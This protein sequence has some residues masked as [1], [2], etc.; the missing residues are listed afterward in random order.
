MAAFEP[1]SWEQAIDEITSK[2][3]GLVDEHGPRSLAYM[4]ASA[5]GGERGLGDPRDDV[6][7]QHLARQRAGLVERVGKAREA[8]TLPLLD[9]IRLRSLDSSGLWSF[10][11]GQDFHVRLRFTSV[12]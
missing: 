4:G 8:P 12:S 5:Q 7:G 10:V 1:I 9:R 11:M 2:M 3:K 6:L